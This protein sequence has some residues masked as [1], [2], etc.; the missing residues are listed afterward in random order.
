M[1]AL[2][3]PLFLLKKFLVVGDKREV[4]REI[5]LSKNP[6]LVPKNL[7]WRCNILPSHPRL[8]LVPNKILKEDIDRLQAKHERP[9]L[10]PPTRLSG[11]KEELQ[12]EEIEAHT[13]QTSHFQ[14]NHQRT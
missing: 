5:F 2:V 14:R 12:I 7:M 4:H 13:F 3:F 10:L 6:S 11:L 9:F 8:G 1:K